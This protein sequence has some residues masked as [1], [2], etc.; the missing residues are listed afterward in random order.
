MKLFQNNKQNKHLKQLGIF[1]EEKNLQS[2]VNPVEM[3]YLLNF[4]LYILLLW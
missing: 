2:M 4:Q 3:N 1:V